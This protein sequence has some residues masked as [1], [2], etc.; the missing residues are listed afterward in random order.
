MKRILTLIVAVLL[1][2]IAVA[3]GLKNQQLINVNYL[4]AEN[5]IRLATLLAIIFFLGFIVA[6][7]FAMLFYLKLKMKNRQLSRL[8]KK[9]HKE[10]NQLR[11]LPTPEKD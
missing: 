2:A 1:F 7:V 5:E 6:T 3:L 4:I 8:N 9:Q 10:L 11:T